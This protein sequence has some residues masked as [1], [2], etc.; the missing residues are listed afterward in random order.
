MNGD[1]FEKVL[2]HFKRSLG[3]KI[4]NEIPAEKLVEVVARFKEIFKEKAGFDFPAD[5]WQQ[6]RNAVE[7]VFKS[8]GN[9]RAVTY[10]RLHKIPHTLGTAVNI[11]SMVYGNL[12]DDCGT[13]VA[14]PRVRPGLPGML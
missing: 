11:V 13:G 8:W 14:I 3:V 5:P 7:A 2:E 10:R 12:G 9:P 6:L 1:A 4:D